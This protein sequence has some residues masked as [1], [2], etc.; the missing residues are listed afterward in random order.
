MKKVATGAI[1]QLYVEGFRGDS[2]NE[3]TEN[4][5][6]EIHEEI[7][8]SSTF[9]RASPP[10]R[11]T[12]ELELGFE[13]SVEDDLESNLTTSTPKTPTPLKPY[14]RS[15]HSQGTS[16]ANSIAGLSKG[17]AEAFSV[18]A[19]KE[20]EVKDPRVGLVNKALSRVNS[21]T[22]TLSVT[23]R[24]KIKKALLAF[25]AVTLTFFMGLDNEECMAFLAQAAEE[26]V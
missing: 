16:I 14:K 3:D 4:E 18:A 12:A 2:E 22:E 9:K 20:L 5:D 8:S 15:R 11:G 1:A 25:D 10:K 17:I 7:S 6:I 23:E 26:E 19:E 24:L 13:D 21:L